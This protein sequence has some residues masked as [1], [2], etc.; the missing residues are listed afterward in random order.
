MSACGSAWQDLGPSGPLF[1]AADAVQGAWDTGASIV[2]NVTSG[3]GFYGSGRLT[4]YALITALTD[5]D[6]DTAAAEDTVNLASPART[7]H[8]LYG[9]ETGGGHMWP[10][11]PGKSVF[12]ASWSGAEFTRGGVPVRYAV[13]GVRDGVPMKVILEPGGEGIISGYPTEP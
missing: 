8:I 9:D 11:A 4:G 3:H 6:G 13:F 2:S 7:Q 10:G 12:P 5:G 1:A